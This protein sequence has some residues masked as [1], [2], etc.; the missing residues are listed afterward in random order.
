[1]ADLWT[2]INDA[3]AT[4]ITPR[5]RAADP[6]STQGDALVVLPPMSGRQS[7]QPTYPE[8][9][10]VEGARAQQA[11]ANHGP[12]TPQ[13]APYVQ[14]S[15]LLPPPADPSPGYLERMGLK[16]KDVL[17]LFVLSLMIAL[18]ISIHWVAS[19]YVNEWLESS[20]FNGRQRLAVRLGYPAILVFVLWNI[21]AFQQ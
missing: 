19:H 9:A 3:Y 6:P 20:D 17:R 4:Q 10:M 21:K 2:D 18:G 13:P 7:T 16:S 12:Y 8:T 5:A 11:A 14:S 1:M 15:S